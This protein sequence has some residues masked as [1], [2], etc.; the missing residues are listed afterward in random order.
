MSE[1]ENKIIEET[2]D[3]KKEHPLKTIADIYKKS[4]EEADAEN[5]SELFKQASITFMKVVNN[6]LRSRATYDKIYKAGEITFEDLNYLDGYFIFGTGT[7]S[8]FHFHVKECP[9]WLFGIWWDKPEK[10]EAKYVEGQ[11]FAQYED[12]IDKFKPSA[13]ELALDFTIVP[14]EDDKCDTYYKVSSFFNFIRTEPYLAFCRHLRGWNY[15]EEYHTR[16]E[17]KKRFIAHKKWADRKE[18]FNKYTEEKILNFYKKYIL[19]IY[20]T[21]A[22]IKPMGEGWS[23]KY[24]IRVPIKGNEDLVTKP[25]CYSLRSDNDPP[26][27]KAIWKR[28]DKMI[29]K[30]E[31]KSNKL[32]IC[33]F[34]SNTLNDS[35]EAYDKKRGSK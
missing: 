32:G 29:D 19:P 1:T 35:F 27:I 17:A 11:L 6:T 15:N 16:R 21:G 8:V 33:W 25:G 31:C 18:K 28:Y 3:I 30:F 10:E 23:P 7:N 24:E 26:E 4:V 12:D 34:E 2:K 5:T 22:T 14:K 9:G 13:S 20:F